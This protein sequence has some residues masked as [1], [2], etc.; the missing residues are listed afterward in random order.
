MVN[1]GFPPQ[2]HWRGSKLYSFEGHTPSLVTG[3]T[4]AFESILKIFLKVAEDP[5]GPEI[6]LYQGR[7]HTS[8]MIILSE[9]HDDFVD[10]EYPANVRHQNPSV[11]DS[12]LLHFSSSDTHKYTG[13]KLSKAQLARNFRKKS[14]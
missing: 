1:Y 5:T 9:H 10:L 14:N 11:N 13:G 12:V 3:N 7:K 8:D 6:S 4:K 2:D